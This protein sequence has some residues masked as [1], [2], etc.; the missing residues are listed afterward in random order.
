MIAISFL[1]A[2]DSYSNQAVDGSIDITGG[3]SGGGASHEESCAVHGVVAGSMEPLR[4]PA[5]T[6][7]PFLFCV[8]HKDYYPAGDGSMQAPRRGNGN[9]FDPAAP[10]RMCKPGDVVRTCHNP[11][12][13]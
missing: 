1:L 6:P 7:D 12:A 11:S 4:F 3:S 13:N 8:Y 5:A 9:D 2:V 10:Y